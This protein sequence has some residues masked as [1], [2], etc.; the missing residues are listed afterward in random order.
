MTAALRYE[1]SEAILLI[2]RDGA[3]SPALTWDFERAGFSAQV[4]HAFARA[5]V[6]LQGSNTI[7]SQRAHWGCIQRFGNFIHEVSGPRNVLPKD[8]LLGFDAWMVRKAL[9]NRTIGATYNAVVRSLRWIARNLPNAVNAANLTP[10]L[11]YASEGKQKKAVLDVPDESATRRILAACYSEIELIEA[12]IDACKKSLEQPSDD[13]I[14]NLVNRLLALGGGILPKQSELLD[15]ERPAEIL[16][17]LRSLGGLRA[18][19]RRLY[20]TPDD[21]LPFYLSIL[22]Q[23]CGNPQSLLHASSD[24]IASV[25][26]RQDLE[27]VI[28]T[29][30]RSAREQAVDF[31]REK[32]WAAP[33]IIR[34]LLALNKELRSFAVPAH[35]SRLFLA[36]NCNGNVAA[37]SW[38]GLHNCYRTFRA[39]HELPKFD[40]RSF[41]VAGAKAH[42]RAASD[43]LAA[44]NRLQHTTAVVTQ[45]YTPLQDNRAVH[46]VTIQ[47]FQGQMI[48]EAMKFQ[49]SGNEYADQGWEEKGAD[50]V[51]GF[52]CKDPVGG[53]AEGSRPGEVCLHFQQCATCPGAIVVVD[54]P[55]CV[56]KLIS[57]RDHLR[58]EYSRALREG[59]SRRFDKLYRPTL[60]I[61]EL[62]ILPAIS[63][64]VIARASV[65]RE[66][67]QLR[68]E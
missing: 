58:E 55:G 66:V 14:P 19:G 67:K 45:L 31:S 35:A 6:A 50:T 60:E 38:Q 5:H 30:A 65:R 29:K 13:R 36:R 20:L 4:G 18:I 57:A 7:E 16:R 9:A 22:I 63:S 53:L 24:C 47:H 17:E 49:R 68:L 11:S 39:R 43:L 51:F 44:A 10:R 21:I 59:W 33:N 26:M 64:K 32:V 40:F 1:I 12:R 25:P 2:Y 8:C 42:H 56:S 28:W 54:D 34:R 52:R 41:R 46:D 27:R 48:W 15:A 23:T 3:S 62:E 61:I 37:M